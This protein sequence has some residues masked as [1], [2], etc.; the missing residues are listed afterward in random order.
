[1]KNIQKDLLTGELLISSIVIAE[2]IEYEHSSFIALI[3]DELTDLQ[4]YGTLEFQMQKSTEYALLNEDQAVLVVT[5]L[6]RRELVKKLTKIER[7]WDDY[8]K[9]LPLNEAKEYQHKRFRGFK[10]YYIEQLNKGVKK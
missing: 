9:S 7:F 1:M 6:N 10:N 8:I 2:S 5:Y 3:K 4:E